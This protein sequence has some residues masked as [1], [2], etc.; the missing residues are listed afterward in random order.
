[1]NAGCAFFNQLSGLGNAAADANFLGL[2]RIISDRFEFDLEFRRQA[3]TAHGGDSEHL[4]GG[5]NREQTGNNRD[6]DSERASGFYKIEVMPVIIKKLRDDT[7]GSSVDLTLEVL[8]VGF[9]VWRFDMFLRVTGNG[10]S[11]RTDLA[12]FFPG[13]NVTDQFIGVAVTISWG[14][15]IF[16]ALGRVPAKRYDIANA[17]CVNLVENRI[18]VAA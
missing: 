13:A 7:I 11:H 3:G 4:F 1:M 2:D 16:L 10:D 12:G 6:S 14:N 18:Q 17:R 5:E 9:H 15:E 8:Q